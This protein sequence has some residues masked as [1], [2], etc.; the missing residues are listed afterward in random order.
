M[1]TSMWRRG[2]LGGLALVGLAGG[3]AW[4]QDKAQDKATT[5]AK[6]AATAL[7][8]YPDDLTVWPN[9]TSNANSDK[10]LVENHDKIK[11]MRPRVLVLNF[12]NGFAPE[13]AEKTAKEL[14]AAVTE[15][16]RYHGYKDPKA[17][18]FI[19]WQILKVVDLRDAEPY[20]ETPDGNC[21]KYPRTGRKEGI[22]FAY[23]ELYS[24]KFAEYYSFKDPKN[25]GKYLKLNE[26][27]AQGIVHELWFFAYQRSAGAPFEATEWKP[28]YDEKFQRVGDEHRHAGNGGDQDEPWFGRSLRISFI[29]SERGIGCNVES[30][31]HAMEGTANSSVIPYYRKYFYEYASHDLDKRFKLPW[32]SFYAI[33]APG[34]G[35]S[36]PDDHTAVV[37]KLVKA[38]GKD[39]MKEIRVDN[40]YCVGG[41]VHFIPS[42]RGHYDLDSPFTALSTIE[43]YRLFDGPDGKDLAE[44]WNKD[45]FAQYRP[46]APD[47]MGCWLIYWRQNMPGYKSPCKDDDGK[48]LKNWWPFL[49]Y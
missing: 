5:I 22:N 7:P 15:G 20:P 19:E 10:W 40:Y 27:V 41:N 1:S 34:E 24:D 47:C 8:E 13:K 17:E 25:P 33:G 32:N 45:K 11:K 31:S 2:V 16:T 18:P 48:P 21:T 9:K 12:S 36:Y 14:A 44:P 3:A 29:N 26:L 42:S 35:I 28:V 30:L 46:M 39:V 43:H 37:K 49:F 38:D 6:P 23:K 4:A